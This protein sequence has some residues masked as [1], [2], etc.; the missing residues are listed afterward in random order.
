MFPWLRARS[1]SVRSLP[2][3]FPFS[4]ENFLASRLKTVSKMNEK[5]GDR[6]DVP[7]NF[8]IPSDATS[9]RG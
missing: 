7:I 1:L 6:V 4:I 5:S 8:Q 9:D 3:K 2:K